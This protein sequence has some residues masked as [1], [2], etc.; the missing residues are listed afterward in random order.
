MLRKLLICGGASL[1]L[2]VFY[3]L[4]SVKAETVSPVALRIPDSSGVF[5]LGEELE[6]DVT[7]LSLRLGS[8]VFK[9]DSVDA[10]NGHAVWIAHIDI[11]SREGIPFISLHATQQSRIDEAGFSR[12]FIGSFKERSGRWS[13]LKYA[14]DYPEKE[15]TVEKGKD[16]QIYDHRDINSPLKYNDGVSLIYYVR[17]N[18]M[19]KKY[20]SVPTLVETDTAHTFIHFLGECESQNIDAV[21]YPIDCLHFT[22]HAAWTGI[23]GLTG[24]F[25]GW[26]SND[27][28]AVPIKARMQLYVGSVW[29]DLVRWNRPDWKPPIAGVSANKD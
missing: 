25:E 29:I 9:I 19:Y 18:G 10:E 28:D 26:L 4:S 12:Y 7:F 16:G 22:G 27:A 6:Y 13:Y 3:F 24:R 5:E 1:V 14:F 15:I 17:R 2:C 23:Y 8:L 11:N 21:D 20:V